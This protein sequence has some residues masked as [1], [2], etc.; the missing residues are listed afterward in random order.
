MSKWGA[1]IRIFG[2]LAYFC[3]K[4]VN[5]DMKQ[6]H[7]LY[8]LLL[9]ALPFIS[10][11]TTTAPTV[12]GDTFGEGVSNPDAAVAF[13]DVVKQ[14]DSV[15]SVNVVMKGKVTEVCQAKGCWMNIVDPVS[16]T[17]ESLFVQFKDYGFFMPKDIAGRE[18]IL[19]GKAYTESTS[20][21]DLRHYAEDAGKSAEEI[22]AIT[23]PIVEKKFMASGVVL[24]K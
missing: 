3:G 2:I 5:T 1:K 6:A 7:F 18:V 23:E 13:S 12:Q 10:C 9:A 21:E 8:L 19:E 11:K 20:V 15:D 14:L 22:A 4:I 17:E 24:L 16:G